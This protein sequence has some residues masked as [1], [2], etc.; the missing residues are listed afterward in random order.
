MTKQSIKLLLLTFSLLFF[1]LQGCSN[2]STDDSAS[3]DSET[4][5]DANDTDSNITSDSET[6]TSADTASDLDSDTT[7]DRT[8]MFDKVEELGK[9]VNLGNWLEAWPDQSWG[10]VITK[11]DI[12]RI[13]DQ[14][15]DTIRVPAKW[16]PR[17]LNE[18]PY[19]ID[20]D[21][22]TI[23]DNVIKWATDAG[24]NVVIDMHH[25]LDFFDDPDTWTDKFLGMWEQIAVRYADKDDNLLFE[26][27]NEPNTELTA[28]KWNILLAKALTVIRES[29][30]KRAVVIGT[31]EWGGIAAMNKLILPNDDNIIFTFHYYSPFQFTHQGADWVDG[32]DAWLGTDFTGSYFER[33]AMKNDM[34][35]V[36]RWSAE[37]DIPVWIGEF[38]AFS[39]AD[40]DSRAIWT[41]TV[42]R[43]AESYD[44]AWCYWEY[45]SGFGVYDQDTQ[46][47]N[48]PLVDALFSEDTSVTELNKE[49]L[50]DNILTNGDFTDDL[51]GWTT[52]FNG[53]EATA[54][55][56]D[57]T[58]QIEITDGGP[59]P[60][61]VQ[62]IN[63]LPLLETGKSY[64]V[65][66]DAWGD[67][68]RAL[69]LGVQH[70]ADPWNSYGGSTV[71]IGTEPSTQVFTFSMTEDDDNAGLVINA[72]SETA[73]VHIDNI[74]ITEIN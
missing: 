28:E 23:V 32:A 55:T 18:E 1:T 70:L 73:T 38:G 43:F 29:N 67:S 69:Y 26:I 12:N 68:Q 25:H 63:A 57:E 4:A 58:L 19:T 53:S 46:S 36:S 14:G 61:S 31:A 59:D 52:N 7:V 13:A 21:F 64:A 54:A 33:L 47:W 17:A 9:G 50:G 74:Y 60:W 34:D 27:M 5:S 39:G 49:Q 16:E 8:A 2:D 71:N 45:N 66:F 11:E 3:D 37:N 42:A 10:V 40:M 20:P 56:V 62:L 41:A 24:L 44:F 30:P 22:F 51:T 72:G 48:T 15:F 35:S 65:L 6:D